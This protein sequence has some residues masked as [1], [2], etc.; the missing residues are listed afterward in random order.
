MLK[1]IDIFEKDPIPKAVA[2]LAIPTVLSML[3]TVFYN[4][5]DTFFVGQLGDPN[6]VAA[7]SIATPVF[8]LLMAIGNIFGIGGSTFLSR[9][10]GEKQM[11]RVRHISSF[12][13]YG[14]I[15]SGL[16]GGF[17]FLLWMTPILKASGASKFTLNDACKYL[18]MIAYGAPFIVLSTAFNNLVRGEGSAKTSMAGM[19]TGTIANIILDPIFILPSFSFG[20]I[21]IPLLGLGVQGAA[22]ATVL[23][24]LI[25]FIFFFVIILSGKSILSLNYKDFKIAGGIFA[26][27]IAIGLPA[28]L[29]NVLMSTSNII[30][31]KLLAHYGDISVASMGIAM[32]ANMLVIFIQIG[33]AAGVQPI[34]AY[35]YGAHNYTRMKSTMYFTM[36]VNVILGTILTALYM[37]F[38]GNIV[39]LFINN[40][41]V[42][43]VGTIMLRAL[44]ISN[45]FLGI[46]FVF[47][48]SFQAMGKATQSLILAV[49]RQGFVFIPMLFIGRLLAG[50]NGIIYAQ[51]VADIAALFIS[52]GMYHSLKKKFVTE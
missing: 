6:K 25:S 2:K 30:M 42:V 29:N 40:E 15:I 51:P 27:V 5:V 9:A 34:I 28:S 13:F 3:I 19:M 21:T 38:A 26:G 39:N 7:V 22:T 16:L 1:N 8:L 12:C 10:L 23:G 32:K 49:S 43:K 4:M 11:K 41:E 50:E 44:M 52:Y 46:M 18:K 47:E 24:N 36:I 31:N 35:N 14:C 45:P 33:L 48:F 20:S 17:I 37:V